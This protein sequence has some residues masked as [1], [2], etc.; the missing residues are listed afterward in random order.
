MLEDRQTDIQT[1]AVTT[2]LRF[3]LGGGVTSVFIYLFEPSAPSDCF[4]WRF[5][6][7]LLLTYFKLLTYISSSLR[8]GMFIAGV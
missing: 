6:S 7:I 2:V 5:V 8:T 3:P 1:H 4:F